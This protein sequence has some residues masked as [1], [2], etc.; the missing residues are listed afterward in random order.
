MFIDIR[1][2]RDGRWVLFD[3]DTGRTIDDAGKSGFETHRTAQNW[4][5]GN[6]LSDYRDRYSSRGRGKKRK[7]NLSKR[8][9]TSR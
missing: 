5:Y 9:E 1:Q 8:K 2:R 4:L 7:P 3:S 6:Y